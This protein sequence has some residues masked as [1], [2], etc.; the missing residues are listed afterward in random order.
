[1]KRSIE[2]TIFK[3]PPRSSLKGIPY[4]F[5]PHPISLMDYVPV[6]QGKLYA[7]DNEKTNDILED[8]FYSVNEGVIPDYHSMDMCSGDVIM[9]VENNKREFWYCDICGWEKTNGEI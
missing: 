5:I 2:Y 3:L 7:K 6:Y 8:I 9:L 1:M 4:A